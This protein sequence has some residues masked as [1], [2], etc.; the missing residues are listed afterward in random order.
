MML[1]PASRTVSLALQV[2]ERRLLCMSAVARS[3]SPN[4]PLH[5]DPSLKTLLQDT[6][7]AILGHKPRQDAAMNSR[8]KGIRELEVYPDDPLATDAYLSPEELDNAESV[9]NNRDSRKSP[10]AL[11]GSQRFGTVVMPLELQGTITKL[12][13]GMDRGLRPD[14]Y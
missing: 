5:L 6:D 3:H 11:F 12:I 14:E 10:A 13:A 8:H 2:A 4:A 7:M 1:R 9:E